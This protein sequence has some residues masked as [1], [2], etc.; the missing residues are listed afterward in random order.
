MSDNQVNELSDINIETWLSNLT[1]VVD[2]TL[3]R[4]REITLNRSVEGSVLQQLK[5]LIISLDADL[6]ILVRVLVLT[7][8]DLADMLDEHWQRVLRE[9]W[10]NIRVRELVDIFLQE[11]WY[12]NEVFL[13]FCATHVWCE[14]IQDFPLILGFVITKSV[15]DYK[16]LEPSLEVE[17]VQ[18]E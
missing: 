14:D 3:Q 4:S 8:K 12:K 15:R 13:F 11:E 9:L 5:E 10:L 16:S 17:S 2:N 7:I 18:P 6:E 1:R